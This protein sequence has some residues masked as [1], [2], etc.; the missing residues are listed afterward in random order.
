MNPIELFTEEELKDIRNIGLNFENRIY[1]PE[2]CG[3]V[4]NKINE[5]IMSES[6]NNIPNLINSLS[7]VLDT[8]IKYQKG[9]N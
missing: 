1:T 9:N 3:L 8:L 4:A 6:K 5:S 7:N 2:E